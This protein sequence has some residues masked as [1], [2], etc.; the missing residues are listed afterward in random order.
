MFIIREFRNRFV[1]D[2][3]KEL[4]E[5]IPS[6]KIDLPVIYDSDDE[7]ATTENAINASLA[8]SFYNKKFP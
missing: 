1:H 4:L 5:Y 2:Y 7:D 3:K 6:G 8:G